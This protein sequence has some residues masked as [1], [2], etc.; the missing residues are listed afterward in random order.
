M[1]NQEDEP[2]DPAVEAIRVK[3]VRLLAISG[4][5]MM[6]G[7]MAVLF[8]IVYKINQ[9]DP[10][11]TAAS[12]GAASSGAPS[13]AALLIPAGAEVIQAMHADRRITL[14]VRLADGSTQVQLHDASGKM[15]ATYLIRER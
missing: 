10:V 12:T 14:L 5:I 6:L 11:A 2:L 9:S 7:L 8:G 4:G 13:E 3:M 1:S 15:T